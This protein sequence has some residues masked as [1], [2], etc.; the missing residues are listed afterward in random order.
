[1]FA[2]VGASSTTALM[3]GYAIMLVVVVVTQFS[4]TA[5]TNLCV[6]S[7]FGFV[8]VILA[9]AAAFGF[10]ALLGLSYNAEML[11]ALPFLALGLGVDDLFLL[12]HHFRIVLT[13][14]DP[15]ISASG[16]ISRMMA[17]AGRSITITSFCNAGVF[18][19]ACLIPIPALQYFLVGAGVVVLFNWIGAMTVLPAI[20]SI[21]ANC[22]FEKAKRGE[23]AAT[24]S[25]PDSGFVAM[26]YGAMVK[27]AMLK[28]LF[29]VAGLTLIVVTVIFIPQVITTDCL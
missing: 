12:L 13:D 25:K 6:I 21:H 24:E 20:F 22:F 4:T 2:E 7:F 27:S 17:H 11:Q 19:S 10:I 26:V 23:L 14:G 3:L 8:M 16:R 15:D 5:E 29:F 9:N 28:V 18:F 1:M